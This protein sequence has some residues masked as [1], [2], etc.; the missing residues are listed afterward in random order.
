MNI[1]YEYT[2]IGPRNENQDFIGYKI[3]PDLFIACI[4]DGVGG[5]KNGK[6]VSNYVVNEFLKCDDYS[7]I[8]SLKD[9]IYSINLKVLELQK[10]KDFS[11]MATTFTVFIVKDKKL[12]GFHVGDTRLCVL[13][14]NGIKQLTKP[15]TSAYRALKAGIITIEDYKNLNFKNI[16]ENAI[17]LESLFIDDFTFDLEIKDRIIIST[18][19]FHDEMSKSE[20]VDISIKNKESLKDCFEQIV[21]NLKYKKFTDNNSFLIYEYGL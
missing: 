2:D 1:V 3:L 11:D 13:R 16:L 15:H 7:D 5:N 12:Y 20:L 10:K 8:E 19:G 4:A 18:D 9:K 6:F 17:G 21:S 14:R